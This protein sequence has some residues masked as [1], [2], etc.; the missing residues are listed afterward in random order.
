MRFTFDREIAD[1]FVVKRS[2]FDSEVA[3]SLTKKVYSF[4]TNNSAV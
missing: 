1:H 4:S 3:L 2:E